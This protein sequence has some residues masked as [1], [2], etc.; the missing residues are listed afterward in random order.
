[1]STQEQGISEANHKRRPSKIE[2]LRQ[3]IEEQIK[4]KSK[5]QKKNKIKRNSFHDNIYFKQDREK[6]INLI[7]ESQIKNKPK[8]KKKK[9]T[10][11]GSKKTENGTQRDKKI[12]SSSKKVNGST[13]N[14]KGKKNKPQSK[15]VIKNSYLRKGKERVMVGTKGAKKIAGN[16]KKKQKLEELTEIDVPDFANISK[17][18]K[19]KSPKTKKKIFRKSQ[20]ISRMSSPKKKTKKMNKIKES[21]GNLTE[22]IPQ[23]INTQEIEIKQKVIKKGS[24]DELNDLIFESKNLHDQLEKSITKEKSPK[25]VLKP[26]K[27]SQSTILIKKPIKKSRSELNI[28]KSKS[29]TPNKRKLKNSSTIKNLKGRSVIKR[30]KGKSVNKKPK[31]KRRKSKSM[32]R[33]AFGN[34]K[35]EEQVEE[36]VFATE[37]KFMRM[38]SARR[39]RPKEEYESGIPLRPKGKGKIKLKKKTKKK[40]ITKSKKRIKLKEDENVSFD[41]DYESG[42]ISEIQ[43]RAIVPTQTPNSKIIYDDANINKIPETAATV[44]KDI[45]LGLHSPKGS[46]S[47]EKYLQSLILEREN[48][49][50]N[51]ESISYKYFQTDGKYSDNDEQAELKNSLFMDNYV[52]QQDTDNKGILSSK[53][54]DMPMDNEYNADHIFEEIT[55]KTS[56]EDINETLD[57]IQSFHEKKEK[58]AENDIYKFIESKKQSTID[59]CE[60]KIKSKTAQKVKIISQQNID[61]E[62]L[63]ENISNS[64]KEPNELDYNQ[65]AKSSLTKIFHK[66]M[67]SNKVISTFE[68]LNDVESNKLSQNNIPLNELSKDNNESIKNKECSKQD[69]SRGSNNNTNTTTQNRT[70]INKEPDNIWN[71]EFSLQR[72]SSKFCETNSIKA[73]KNFNKKIQKKN[74]TNDIVKEKEKKSSGMLFNGGRVI[75]Q[76]NNLRGRSSVA[77]YSMSINKQSKINTLPLIEEKPKQKPFSIKDLVKNN[78]KMVIN[79]AKIETNKCIRADQEQHFNK[80]EE[81]RNETKNKEPVIYSDI[82]YEYK[83]QNW[84]KNY[85]KNLTK[86]VNTKMEFTKMDEEMDLIKSKIEITE[87]NIKND[88]QFFQDILDKEEEEEEEKSKHTFGSKIDVSKYFSKDESII[89]EE[90]EEEYYTYEDSQ[91]SMEDLRS[92]DFSKKTDTVNDQIKKE[93]SI[94]LENIKSE[95]TPKIESIS[96]P[97]NFDFNVE[98]TTSIYIKKN[99]KTE[100]KPKPKVSSDSFPIKSKP[101]KIIKTKKSKPKKVFEPK[102]NLRNSTQFTPNKPIKS[103]KSLENQKQ[104]IRE[105]IRHSKIMKINTVTDFDLKQES[106]ESESDS[107]DSEWEEKM[108]KDVIFNESNRS[109]R[110]SRLDSDYFLHKKG[111]THI[112]RILHESQRIIDVIKDEEKN[113]VIQISESEL[114]KF[115]KSQKIYFKESDLKGLTEKEKDIR[116]RIKTSNRLIK[117]IDQKEP[118]LEDLSPK[119]VTDMKLLIEEPFKYKSFDKLTENEKNERI[120]LEVK[121]KTKIVERIN[122]IVETFS[123]KKQSELVTK[124]ILNVVSGRT[125]YRWKNIQK[126][127]LTAILKIQRFFRFKIEEKI[128]KKILEMQKQYYQTRVSIIK[129]LK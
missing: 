2:E 14:I 36:V 100:E 89:L 3:K 5:K 28:K 16:F 44:K 93:I 51:R 85:L 69:M 57:K 92:I 121:Y 24:V 18:S 118:N 45:N 125:L 65:F 21:T 29:R 40:K 30:G 119:D 10:A 73:I 110:P 35:N 38:K 39:I 59:G 104:I 103:K 22:E 128:G 66:A 19:N 114:E 7:K 43:T 42:F 53:F 96:T 108:N 67:N 127:E 13:K 12:V 109:S 80:K 115:Q 86:K 74:P 75:N 63:I 56:K 88:L 123:G 107:D 101:K 50:V 126:G 23:I 34:D 97:K 60:E 58:N 112:L 129:P 25:P 37:K 20:K 26:I 105:S 48:E 11:K 111:D 62:E 32:T 120:E 47:P 94:E 91:D 72:I 70:S 95:Q 68:N 78:I 6:V 106:S 31:I 55:Q 76:F 90:K 116:K 98:N 81:N 102:L 122:K 4:T 46:E 71:S 79:Q 15:R 77:M 117:H 64:R 83:K 61:F 82:G 113:G 84:I 54:M 27:K 124:E 8:R 99:C 9:I 41:G 87:N 52:R 33:D 17:M 49:S 1:M